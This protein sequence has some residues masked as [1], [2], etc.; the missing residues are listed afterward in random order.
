[1]QGEMYL[2]KTKNNIPALRSKFIRRAELF[3]KL[4]TIL[5]YRMAVIT[6]PA[7]FGKTTLITS[8]L[9]SD[10]KKLLATAWMSLDEEDNN[11]KSFWTYF[12]RAFCKTVPEVKEILKMIGAA[13]ESSESLYRACISMLINEV[14]KLHR[15]II[16]V[17]DDFH[18]IDDAVILKGMKYFVKNMPSNIHVL[19]ASRS[20][21]DFGLTRLRA[22]DALLEIDQKELAFNLEECK[23]FFNEVMEIK[24]SGEEVKHYK[25]ETEGWA[26]GLQLAALSIKNSHNHEVGDKIYSNNQFIFDYIAEEVFSSL[27]KELKDFLLSTSILEQ[28]CFEL[29][30]F[31]LGVNNSKEIIEDIETNNLF[32]MGLDSEK[33]WFRYHNLFRNFLRKKLEREDKETANKL[34]CRAAQ[35]YLCNNQEI[36]AVDYYIKGYDFERAV[37]LMEKICGE[38]LCRGEA[39][40]LYKWNQRLP[41]HIVINNPRLLMNNAWAMCAKGKMYE[42]TSSIKSVKKLIGD[43]EGRFGKQFCDGEK[44]LNDFDSNKICNSETVINNCSEQLDLSMKVEIAALSVTNTVNINDAGKILSDCEYVMEHLQPEG[45][46]KQLIIFNIGRACL[47]KGNIS[48]A[49]KRFEECLSMGIEAGEDYIIIIANKALNTS[50]KWKGKLKEIEYQCS[51]LMEA[52]ESKLGIGFSTEGLL[53]VDLSEIYYQRNELDKSLNMAKKS[54][55]LG[56]LGENSWVIFESYLMLIKIY[57]AMNLNIECMGMITKTEDSLKYGQLVDNKINFICSK[58]KILIDKGMIE[59]AWQLLEEII[60]ALKDIGRIIYPQVYI[61]QIRLMICKHEFLKAREGLELLLKCIETY[62]Y[63]GLKVELQILSAI[64]YELIGDKEAAVK[65]LKEAIKL[66]LKENII[67]VFINDRNKL[68]NLLRD[69]RKQL[70]NSGENSFA[71]YVEK[72]IKSCEDKY[73]N[74]TPKSEIILKDRELEVLRL[75]AEGTA[76]AEIS[77]KLFIS[78]NTVKTHLLNIYTKLDVH[79]RTG[80]LAKA[81]ELKLI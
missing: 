50:K 79:S 56:L 23:I 32:L 2:L 75:L 48:E 24:L 26:V 61:M 15:D 19:V 68:K 39:N 63:Y 67:R 18:L 45:F 27:E 25:T 8:W 10:G 43:T 66:S 3:K 49:N 59:Q 36:K 16:V 57:D 81:R 80:A 13:N 71:E 7:G 47:F 29:C 35:W 52:V 55:D 77:Q 44:P 78:I 74:E 72:I 9:N 73:K 14:L 42:V 12:F 64:L 41:R 58:V 76:N 69:L 31:L 1:M 28:L 34:Y 62:G 51:D 21:P 54:L 11:P 60:F 4:D 30:D 33:I 6:A 17:L 22:V 53:Y 38:I 5:D 40:L 37:K 70:R 46:L 65:E 20:I